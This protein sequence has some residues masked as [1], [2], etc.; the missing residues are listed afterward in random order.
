M[1]SQRDMV[2]DDEDYEDNTGRRKS[3]GGNRRD[4]DCI[5]KMCVG[6]GLCA[7]IAGICAVLCMIIAFSVNQLTDN[8]AIE[9]GIDLGCGW[10]RP[11]RMG[12]G[13]GYSCEGTDCPTFAELCDLCVDG[14]DCAACTNKFAGEIW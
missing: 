2:D 14:D 11:Y 1:T 12:Q 9:D 3:S 7:I 13:S 10:K 5:K 4:E 8:V 6:S